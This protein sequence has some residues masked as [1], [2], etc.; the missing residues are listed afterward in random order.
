MLRYPEGRCGTT[1]DIGDP[2]WQ[3]GVCVC[4][5][6]HVVCVCVWC[7]FSF[8][9]CIFGECGVGSCMGVVCMCKCVVHEYVCVCA[10]MH[11]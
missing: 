9:G 4:E 10:Y 3:C 5:G 8:V 11:R 6:V 2:K 1:A 7:V